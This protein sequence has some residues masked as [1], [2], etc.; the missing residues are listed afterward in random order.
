MDADDSSL[1]ATTLELDHVL[2]VAFGDALAEHAPVNWDAPEDGRRWAR[3]RRSEL[4]LPCPR[5]PGDLILLL[6]IEPFVFPPVLRQQTLRVLVNGKTVRLAHLRMT[7]VL[8]CLIDAA[9]VAGSETLTLTFEHP[10]IAQP[11][12]ISASAIRSVSSA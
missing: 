11:S 1:R 6:T 2:T 9:L 7:T 3:G 12:M 10:N 5:A 4:V 8:A